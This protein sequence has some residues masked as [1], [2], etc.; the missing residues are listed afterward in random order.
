MYFD[1]IQKA[2]IVADLLNDDFSRKVI[3]TMCSNGRISGGDL[4]QLPSIPF[5]QILNSDQI[6]YINSQL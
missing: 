4:S 5:D 6:D 3:M 2:Q 1:T